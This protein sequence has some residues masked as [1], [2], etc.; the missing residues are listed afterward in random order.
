[1]T[2]F[3]GG[4]VGIVLVFGLIN[5]VLYVGQNWAKSDDRARLEQLKQRLASEESAIR[6]METSLQTEERT[7]DGLSS[8]IASSAAR[9][10]YLERQ[11]PYGIPS[12]VYSSYSLAIDNHNLLVADYNARIEG[13]QPAF[14]RYESAIVRYN[15][16]VEE[17]NAAAKKAGAGNF[18]I[19][20]VPRGSRHTSRAR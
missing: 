7:L 12:S 13:Y 15:Q 2:R 17:A 4:I 11:Y 3:I 6:A 16:L 10:E 19:I 1:M 8:S 18:Y 20:P 9:I 14:S 5:G